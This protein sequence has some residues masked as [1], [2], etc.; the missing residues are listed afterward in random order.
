VILFFFLFVIRPVS[1]APPDAWFSKFCAQAHTPSD[2]SDVDKHAAP[3]SR[4]D[5]PKEECDDS[6]LVEHAVQRAASFEV[7]SFSYRPHYYSK[8]ADVALL[9]PSPVTAVASNGRHLANERSP[10]VPPFTSLMTES[11]IASSPK[12]KR[13]A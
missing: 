7:G 8:L 2:F 4:G 9:L 3:R 6:L 1:V 5:E 10:S 11:S 12:D 13:S